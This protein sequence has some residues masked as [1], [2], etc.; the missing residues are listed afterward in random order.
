MRRVRELATGISG[1]VV[2]LGL[3]LLGAPTSTAGGPTSVL[4]VSPESV[5]SAALHYPDEEYGKLE[6]LLGKP[7]RDTREEP[8]ELGV[9]SG[10][11]INVTW[12]AHDVSPRRVDRVYPGSPGSKEVWIHTRPT[13]RRP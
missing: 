1:L 7:G 6:R 2:A 5:E 4:V 10:R 13:S 3:V 9:G 11:Q 12:M 8:P